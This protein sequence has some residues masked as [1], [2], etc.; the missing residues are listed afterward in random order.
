MTLYRV[1]KSKELFY[2]VTNNQ[3][4]VWQNFVFTEIYIMQLSIYADLW[5]LG[6]IWLHYYYIIQVCQEHHR[7]KITKLTSV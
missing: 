1:Y 4:R 7:N 3:Y 6:I 2:F 5:T